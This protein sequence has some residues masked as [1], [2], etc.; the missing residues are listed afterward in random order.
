MTTPLVANVALLCC[1]LDVHVIST[2]GSKMSTGSVN[3]TWMVASR[4]AFVPFA[5]G[6]VLNTSGPISTIGAVRLGAGAPVAKSL[7]LLV[8]VLPLPDRK[9][10]AVFPGDGAST[11]L[12]AIQRSH[13]RR[14][15]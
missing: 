11:F 13:N 6:S 7:S 1:P 9:I 10:D 15:P 2:H 12:A 14:N 3:V 5:R 8:S 4:G